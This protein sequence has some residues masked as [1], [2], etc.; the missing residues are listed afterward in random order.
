MHSTNKSAS[1][2]FDKWN[3]KKGCA[4]SQ[5]TTISVSPMIGLEI[6]DQYRQCTAAALDLLLLQLL[7]ALQVELLFYRQKQ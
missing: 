5:I 2:I 4:E 1:I 7:L 3:P 6:V